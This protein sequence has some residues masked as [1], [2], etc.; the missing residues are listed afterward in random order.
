[1]P[2][3]FSLF[4]SV[5]SGSRFDLRSLRCLLFNG[6][7]PWP[8]ST[9]PPPV[10]IRTPFPL[11][12]ADLCVGCVYSCVFF[13]LFCSVGIEIRSTCCSIHVSHASGRHGG[14]PSNAESRRR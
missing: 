13:V 10:Q 8:L 7:T 4:A 3:W 12:R 2:P 9:F 1:R 11:W 5:Q 6:S 14:Q